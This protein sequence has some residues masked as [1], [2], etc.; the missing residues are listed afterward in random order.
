[1]LVI[2]YWLAY[3]EAGRLP[4]IP[5]RATLVFEVELMGWD[6]APQ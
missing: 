2:P 4:T 1:L 5:E 6:G 3:G